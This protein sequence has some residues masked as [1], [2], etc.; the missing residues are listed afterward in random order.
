[1]NF[2]TEEIPT[3]TEVELK[4]DWTRRFDNMQQH[5]GGVNCV[6]VGCSILYLIYVPVNSEG[7][8]ETTSVLRPIQKTTKA[9]Y[10]TH[11]L[12]WRLFSCSS[13]LS[14]KF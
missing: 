12:G 10:R 14:M 7:D 2:V 3:G 9:W 13:Q 5:S 4:V 11:D 1:M 6:F 8:M